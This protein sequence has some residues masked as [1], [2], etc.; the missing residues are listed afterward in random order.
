MTYTS[1]DTDVATVAA[2]GTLTAVAPGKADITAAVGDKSDTCTVV[3]VGKPVVPT[4]DPEK[5]AEKAAKAPAK[6]PHFPGKQ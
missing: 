3:V 6:K 5:P 4:V 1:S 2:D